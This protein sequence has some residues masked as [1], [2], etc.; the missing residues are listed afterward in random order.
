MDTS[1]TTSGQRTSST[2]T[3]VAGTPL[4][5]RHPIGAFDAPQGG[6]QVF[7]DAV[8]LVTSSTSDVALQT[9][10]TGASDP[11]E[12]LFA[13]NGLLVRTS[14]RSELIVPTPWRGRLSFR[15]GNAGR[16]EATEHLV[17]GPC[18]GDEAWIAFPGGYLVPD[19]ACVDFIVRTDDVDH[20]VTVGVGAPC[21]GQRPPPE[22]SDP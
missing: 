7:G 3:T 6:Y 21:A 18:D 1:P 16:R 2:M 17:V 13:K 9:T 15:W 4:D 12:R 10:A 8:A 5:C 11:S 14:T 20:E 22:P 19:A